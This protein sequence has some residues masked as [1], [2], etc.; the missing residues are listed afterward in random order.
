MI[1]VLQQINS[2]EKIDTGRNCIFKD[3]KGTANIQIMCKA[4]RDAG[5]KLIKKF[6]EVIS[7][8]IKIVATTGAI[9]TGIGHMDGF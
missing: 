2:K 4:V 3:K 6:K 5:D 1:K 7:I 8:K 9:G